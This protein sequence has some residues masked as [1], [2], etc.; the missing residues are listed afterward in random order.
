MLMK[1]ELLR[2][3]LI[4][5]GADILAERLIEISFQ[6]TTIKKELELLVLKHQPK[7]LAKKIRQEINAIKRSTTFVPWNR[8]SEFTAQLYQISRSI[9]YDV[10][11]KAPELAIE[12]LEKFFAIAG[13]IHERSDDFHGDIGLFYHSLNELWGR[14][15]LQIPNRN[16]NELAEKVCELLQ[17]NDYAEKD[18]IIEH[19]AQALGEAGLKLLENLIQKNEKHFS[20][21]S[22]AWMYEKIADALGDV[23]K[24]IAAVKQYSVVNDIIVC[25]IA[26]RLIKKGRGKEAINWLLQQSPTGN[27]IENS[28]QFD[29]AAVS[30][31]KLYEFLIEAYASEK[32]IAEAQALRW[33]LFKKTLA[34]RYYEGLLTNQSPD[35]IQEIKTE[36]F[37]FACETYNSTL[38][39]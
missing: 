30:C 5:L 34:I 25:D 8:T 23:D 26:E 3:H 6:N 7:E 36:A 9:E 11:P 37:Q 20:R 15:W 10:L 35:K 4:E 24:Y 22:I 1:P 13:A 27:V 33:L 38:A 14:A 39:I 2:K 32:F 19:S 28:L 31:S 17:D 12:L 29:P 16:L 18:H 21:Y